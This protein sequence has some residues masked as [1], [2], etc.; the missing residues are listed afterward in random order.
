MYLKNF[1][2]SDLSGT[3]QISVSEPQGLTVKK[4]TKGQT[5]KTEQKMKM[6]A[7]EEE[8]E[9]EEKMKRKIVI[10]VDDDDYYY[11]D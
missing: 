1:T 7:E 2:V 8:E 11:Y 4:N 5:R 3:E 6:E 9:E 10:V